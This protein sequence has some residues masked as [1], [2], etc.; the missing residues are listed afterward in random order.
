M[1]SS[2]LHCKTTRISARLSL[3]AR[4]CQGVNTCDKRTYQHFRDVSSVTVMD[5]IDAGACSG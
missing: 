4:L 5:G 2:V 3:L 1:L